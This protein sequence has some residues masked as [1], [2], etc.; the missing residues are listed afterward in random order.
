MRTAA[1]IFTLVLVYLVCGSRSCT[2]DGQPHYV[3]QEERISI[4]IDSV[5]RQFDKERLTDS[6]LRILEATAGQKL[7]EWADYL[8]IASDTTLAP[9][10]RNKAREMS[11]ELFIPGSG[12]PSDGRTLSSSVPW[13]PDSISIDKALT[14]ADDSTYTGSLGFY[15]STT[16][17]PETERTR[18]REKITICA[19]R[20]QKVFGND[21]LKPWTVYLG[22][23]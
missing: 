14:A 4:L 3:S 10:F 16:D 21:T 19:A 7:S 6:D 2:D 5:T 23:R 20:V 18:I 11:R 15:R 13:I 17:L 22:G 1:F 9:A 12:A 8:R